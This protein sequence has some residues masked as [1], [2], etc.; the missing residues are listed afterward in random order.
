[1]ETAV[2]GSSTAGTKLKATS[3]WNNAIGVSGNGTNDYEFSALPGGYGS[4]GGSFNDR[5]NDG[6]WWSAMEEGASTAYYRSMNYNNSFVNRNY[7]SKSTLFSVRC[8]QD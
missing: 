4:P 3:G 7:R 8:L 1:L 2:G 6:Y 5:G